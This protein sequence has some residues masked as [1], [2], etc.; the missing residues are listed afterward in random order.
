MKKPIWHPAV[1][2]LIPSDDSF[3]CCRV[4]SL[5]DTGRKASTVHVCVA[6][7]SG[8]GCAG[9]MGLPCAKGRVEA[10]GSGKRVGVLWALE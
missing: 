6:Q 10:M 3:P 4:R 9:G 1:F 5:G 2:H 8:N 7:N